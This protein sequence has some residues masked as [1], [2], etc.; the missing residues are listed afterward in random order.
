MLQTPKDQVKEKLE[1]IK[2][3]QNRKF[4]LLYEHYKTNVDAVYQQQNLKLTATQQLEQDQL[5][6]DLDRQM[7]VLNQSHMNRKQQQSDTFMKEI[8]HLEMEKQQKMYELKAKIQEEIEQFELT[9]KQRSGKL[10]E[11]QR[12]ALD[13][14]DSDCYEK[15]SIIT[16][17]NHRYSVYNLDM[18][19][20]SSKMT[21]NGVVHQTSSISSMNPIQQQQQQ[22][23]QQMINSFYQANNLPAPQVVYTIDSSLG[24]HRLS[25]TSNRRNSTSFNNQ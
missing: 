9:N 7:K 4:S 10:K 18:D 23:P 5:N 6:D 17:K 21:S 20:A 25:L 22:S 3:E 19:E 15:Y 2:D 11:M 12:L 14:F 1:Q 16:N 8:E 13:K 24:H